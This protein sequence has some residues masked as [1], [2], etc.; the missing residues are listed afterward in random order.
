M[1]KM[2]LQRADRKIISGFKDRLIM[3][4]DLP[5]SRNIEVIHHR[6]F[7]HMA[8]KK[9]NFMVGSPMTQKLSAIRITS[10][11]KITRIYALTPYNVFDLLN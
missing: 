2:G 11:N 5:H 10:G 4:F 3:P 7:H 6:K 9:R 1:H 8:I